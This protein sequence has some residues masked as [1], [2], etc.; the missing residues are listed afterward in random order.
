MLLKFAAW[1]ME[2]KCMEIFGVL[3]WKHVFILGSSKPWCWHL[4]VSKIWTPSSL[5]RLQLMISLYHEIVILLWIS[6]RSIFQLDLMY[7][8][9]ALFHHSADGKYQEKQNIS[10]QCKKG[11]PCLYCR[12]TVSDNQALSCNLY[13]STLILGLLIRMKYALSEGT[14]VLLHSYM[15]L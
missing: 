7:I 2:V 14:L 12:P 8:F 13:L 15:P 11:T 9:S 1:C 6:W 10:A 3:F 4:Q 5:W